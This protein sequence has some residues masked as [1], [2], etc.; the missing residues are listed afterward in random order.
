VKNSDVSLHKQHSLGVVGRLL[1]AA[2]EKYIS[3]IVLKVLETENLLQH[4]ASLMLQFCNAQHAFLC[5]DTA[6]RD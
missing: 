1:E 5:G 4:S 6:L 3:F 2:E